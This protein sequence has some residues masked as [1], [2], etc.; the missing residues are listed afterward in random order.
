MV[1]KFD[2]IENPRPSQLNPGDKLSYNTLRE[3]Q[4]AL[5]DEIHP[6]QRRY[7][8]IIGEA[9]GKEGSLTTDVI[10]FSM[11]TRLAM[12]RTSFLK[13]DVT[14]VTWFLIA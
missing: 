10:G 13:L 5:K 3:H 1:A 6:P 4:R 14:C 7:R 9:S 2:K 12:I 11:L 8:C